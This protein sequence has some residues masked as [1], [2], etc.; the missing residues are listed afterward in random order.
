MP[1]SNATRRGAVRSSLVDGEP[2]GLDGLIGIEVTCPLAIDGDC[3]S[4]CNRPCEAFDR[5]N[6]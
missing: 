1:A 4:D 6:P 3:P 2:W 5:E